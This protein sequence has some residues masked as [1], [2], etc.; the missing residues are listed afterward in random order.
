MDMNDDHPV[1]ERYRNGSLYFLPIRK[2]KKCFFGVLTFSIDAAT[3]LYHWAIKHQDDLMRVFY[4]PHH[5]TIFTDEEFWAG[6][7][8]QSG[9][10]YWE[11]Y[12]GNVSGIE[13][14]KTVLFPTLRDH[15]DLDV[16]GGERQSVVET[17]DCHVTFTITPNKSESDYKFTVLVNCEEE[18]FTK[19]FLDVLSDNYDI[20]LGNNGK[21][22]SFR[23]V[24]DYE[25]VRSAYSGHQTKDWNGYRYQITYE[26]KV[27][28]DFS[29]EQIMTYPEE[30]LR[31][32][33][34]DFDW[35]TVPFSYQEEGIEYGLSH[36]RFLL[37]DSQGLGKTLESATIASIRKQ[38]LGY[39][40]CLI[41]CC[42]NTLKW[43]WANEVKQH[44]YEGAHVLGSYTKRD[45]KVGY[46]VKKRLSDLDDIDA[47]PYF[48]ITNIEFLRDKKAVSR[49][50]DLIQDNKI[51]MVIA[52]EVHKC[53][54]PKAAQTSGLLKL[55]PE[56]RIAMTGTPI[57][58][59][60]TDVYVYLKWLGFEK[61]SYS[62]FK[63]FYLDHKGHLRNLSLLD[64]NMDKL[65]L[66]RTKEEVLDL[67]PKT[68]EDQ[69][70]ELSKEHQKL[71]DKVQEQAE[72]D[73]NTVMEKNPNSNPLTVLLHLRQCTL[74]PLL[75]ESESEEFQ[76]SDVQ[77]PSLQEKFYRALDL[78]ENAFS[79]GESV[80]CFCTWKQ[81]LYDFKRF[82]DEKLSAQ[83]ED[84][85]C[86]MITGDTK[87]T[88]RMEI[89]EKFQNNPNPEVL[90]GTTG[91]MGTGITLTKATTVIFL[92]EP[93][94]D[95]AKEQ[96]VDR[97]YRIG[98]KSHVTIYT[99][100][101]KDTIDERVHELLFYKKNVSSAIIDKEEEARFLLGENGLLSEEELHPD[102]PEDE[103]A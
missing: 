11:D 4:V 23:S 99:L 1:P 18:T 49:L 51:N 96:A 97:C 76:D 86:K 83:G 81:P 68:Y 13:P 33:D 25:D 53:K 21:G 91:A 40:H 39:Q 17:K 62:M 55:Q 27:P 89:V 41:I 80:V 29:L 88:D 7:I 61:H 75:L 8:P 103:S 22:A 59:N 5:G 2:T 87:D 12:E 30:P 24:S 42:V 79:N 31:A 69:I 52:D 46:D 43:N 70:V 48:L 77:N 15:L 6:Y 100:I 82:L 102:E 35:K 58:N 84:F 20:Y 65:M 50:S 85:S 93:W 10:Y 26:W 72:A 64:S 19:H 71:Y 38:Q 78:I 67:P 98:T 28:K 3:N 66:R 32:F 54:N 37:C 90:I 57:M 16:A 60:P 44:T 92:D 14:T 95:A 74:D 56:C 73:F 101:A 9:I 34:E 94:T 47:L 36:D 45:G 63:D